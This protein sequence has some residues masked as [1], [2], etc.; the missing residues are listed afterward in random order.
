MASPS[1]FVPGRAFPPYSY[2]PGRSLPHPISDPGGHQFGQAPEVPAP[3]D[4]ALWH[5]SQEYL[6]GLDL[7]NHGYYWEAHEAWEGLW[8]VAGRKGT[9]ADFLKALIKLAAAG[10]KHLEGKPEGVRSH[11]S[12]AAAHLRDVAR[13]LAADQERFLGFP[14]QALIELAEAINQE[15]WPEPA[16]LL[17]PAFPDL[18]S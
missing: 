4:P 3:L 15:G 12:R 8:H 18:P 5:E 13:R 14:L 1:R 7:F 17:Q 10:V 9:L 16:P 6:W 11:T 2:V